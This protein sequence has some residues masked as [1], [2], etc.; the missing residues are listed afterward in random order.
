MALRARLTPPRTER[1]DWTW[2]TVKSESL[3]ASLFFGGARRM[4]AEGFLSSGF[5]TRTAIEAKSSGWMPLRNIARVWQPSRLK[6]IQVDPLFG[7]PFLTAT[8]VFDLRPTPRKWLS[9]E[10]T[11]NVE[12]RFVAPGTILVTCSGTVG[13]ATLTRNSLE[14]D[15]CFP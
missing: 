4:E 7:T 3:P 13:R 1:T 6:G 5:R 12:K 15:P 2:H 14:N 11:D 10:R 9:L 8:Q